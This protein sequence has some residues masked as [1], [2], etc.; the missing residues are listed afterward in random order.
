M[1]GITALIMSK[2]KVVFKDINVLLYELDEKKFCF[3]I[4][5]IEKDMKKQEQKQKQ[6]KEQEQEQ[7]TEVDMII[8][9]SG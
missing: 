2:N 9:N 5:N 7:E 4:N 3:I 6:E 1:T 8:Q